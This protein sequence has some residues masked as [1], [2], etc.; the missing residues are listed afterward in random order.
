M[1]QRVCLACRATEVARL[2]AAQP[3]DDVITPSV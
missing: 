2:Y 1:N 3:D